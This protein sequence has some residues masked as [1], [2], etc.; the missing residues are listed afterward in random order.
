MACGSQAPSKASPR[1]VDASRPRARRCGSPNR[2]PNS[3]SCGEAARLSDLADAA[4]IAMR[5]A[6]R[7]PTRGAILAAQHDADFFG[8]RRLS[9]QRVHHRLGTRC[10]A[11]PLQI[12]PPAHSTPTT[13]SRWSSPAP[14]GTTT[15]RSCA[16]HVVG[17]PAAVAPSSYHAAARERA[18]RPARAELQAPAARRG[19][20]FA[21]HARVL[22]EAR[23]VGSIA[24][25]LA[26]TRSAPS[27]RPPGWTRRCSTLD[28][29]AQSIAG[30][31]SLLPPH[32]PD[33]FGERGRRCAWAAHRWSRP[34]GAV[35]LNA[36]RS[37]PRGQIQ[38]TLREVFV[39]FGSR[40]MRRCGGDVMGRN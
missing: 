37:G 35:P 23:P 40:R 28:N 3:S 6:G 24:S 34:D 36:P 9:R 12:R 22:D 19:D 39:R 21:A 30:R 10:P 20:V 5:Y 32:D 38:L 15:P 2:P 16:P 29:P 25:R 18:V 1:L 11:L 26:A 7:A 27:S 13:R 33:G 4:A 31:P 14:T 17:R 8:R